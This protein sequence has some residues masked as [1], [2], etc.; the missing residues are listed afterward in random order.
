MPRTSIDIKKIL[1]LL[2]LL[3]PA[4]FEIVF[5]VIDKRSG[6]RD[7]EKGSTRALKDMMP[8]KY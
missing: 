8:H 6:I 4:L 3:T 5:H 1:T 2:A 7:G